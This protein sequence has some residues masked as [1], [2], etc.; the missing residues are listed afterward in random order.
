MTIQN[1]SSKA[2]IQHSANKNTAINPASHTSSNTSTI[3]K[4]NNTIIPHTSLVPIT[5]QIPNKLRRYYSTRS[6]IK[7]PKSIFESVF[8]VNREMPTY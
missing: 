4:D 6:S 8:S 2:F 1:Y 3:G 5:H 7:K